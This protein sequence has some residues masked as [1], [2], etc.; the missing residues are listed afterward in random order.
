MKKIIHIHVPKTGG[1]WLND[2]LSEHF[3]DHFCGGKGEHVKLSSC[4][5]GVIKNRNP[6]VYAGIVHSDAPAITTYD[7]RGLSEFWKVSIC[8]NPFDYLVSYYHHQP[9]IDAGKHTRYLEPGMVQGQNNINI[10][11]NFRS[12]DEFIKKF[13]DHDFPLAQDFEDMRRFLF[14]QMFDNDGRCAVDVIMRNECLHSATTEMVNNLWSILY[15]EKG[16]SV[17][18]NKK[19]ENVSQLRKKKDHRSYYTDELREL[20]EQ[21]CMAELLLF[22]YDFDGPINGNEFVDPASLFYCPLYP[23][24]GKDLPR[25]VTALHAGVMACESE[26]RTIQLQAIQHIT[27]DVYVATWFEESSED[28]M[29]VRYAGNDGDP[30]PVAECL[31]HFGIPWDHAANLIKA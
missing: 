18:L 9:K 20:V 27:P 21:K 28:F 4:V 24:A 6:V 23:V 25:Q 1:S 7:H 17:V 29:V 5:T 22:E 3:P 16:T 19:R 15:P 26:I 8:R 31:D 12:F 14:Y 11:H 30:K 10:I 2:R 13:C